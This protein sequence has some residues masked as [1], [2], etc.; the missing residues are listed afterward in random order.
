MPELGAPV[1]A[2][3]IFYESL[4]TSGHAHRAAHVPVDTIV[5]P[6][7]VFQYDIDICDAILDIYLISYIDI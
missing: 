2:A 1:S 5:F 3:C 6:Q 7:F 4:F